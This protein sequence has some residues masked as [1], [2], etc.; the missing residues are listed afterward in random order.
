MEN[1]DT[2]LHN[3]TVTFPKKPILAL[4]TS[5]KR[6]RAIADAAEPGTPSSKRVAIRR[7]STSPSTTCQGLSR[8]VEPY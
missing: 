1:P 8:S 4:K 7:V 6:P 2:P 3:G 5:S